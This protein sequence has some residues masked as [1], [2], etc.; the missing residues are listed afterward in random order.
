V[1]EDPTPDQLADELAARQ[2]GAISRRQALAVRLT[3][4]QIAGRVASGRWR[5]A[6][7]GV[8][9]VAAV[10][11]TWEQRAAV[12]C[13]A[14]PSGTVASHLTAAALLGLVEPPAVPEVTVPAGASSRVSGVVVHRLRHL[15]DAHDLSTIRGIPSTSA[16]RTIVDCVGVLDYDAFCELLDTALIR[17]LVTVREVRASAHRAAHAPGRKGLS[18]IE[19]ALEVWMTGRRP[20]STPEMKLV[21]LILKWG[22]PR[23]ERQHPV[24]DERG[25]FV[26]RG[27]VAI[28]R[29]R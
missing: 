29:G 17:R 22:F 27:D 3:R 10:P 21:R 7:R 16:A 24:F 23:P 28:P 8:F 20:D 15:L 11:E 13:L 25:R 19:D 9:V 4:N 5:G 26:A 14:G 12:A 1:A 2:H 18:R 6:A